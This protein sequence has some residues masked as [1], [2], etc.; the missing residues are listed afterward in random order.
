MDLGKIFE[1]YYK[2]ILKIFIS[3]LLGVVPIWLVAGFLYND[4]F[5][6]NNFIPLLSKAIFLENIYKIIS[7]ST[8]DEDVPWINMPYNINTLKFTGIMLFLA[9]I[10]MLILLGFSRLFLPLVAIV[11]ILY[12]LMEFF[13]NLVSLIVY[14]V[15]IFYSLDKEIGLKEAIISTFTLCKK[16][17]LLTLLIS[18]ILTIIIKP[19]WIGMAL[20]LLFFIFAEFVRVNLSLEDQYE[21]GHEDYDYYDEY[22]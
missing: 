18:L 2:N 11:G 16:Y 20:W 7:L 4:N 19:L 21:D 14:G 17:F 22:Y 12:F 6:F 10:K 13:I 5:I 15:F 9:F 8:K 1:D 3:G